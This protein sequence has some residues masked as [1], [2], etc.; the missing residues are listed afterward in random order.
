MP[1]RARCSGARCNGA[2]QFA[3][4]CRSAL[5]GAAFLVFAGYIGLRFLIGAG[6]AAK[7]MGAALLALAAGMFLLARGVRRTPPPAAMPPPQHPAKA[8][9]VQPADAAIIAVFTAAFLLGRQ[10][11][12]HLADHNNH[13]DTS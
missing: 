3:R 11:A 1:C 13:S 6:L 7:G 10:P 8:T 9:S 5:Q 4:P 12:E 2:R